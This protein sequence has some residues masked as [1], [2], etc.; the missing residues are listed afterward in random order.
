MAKVLEKWAK[1][2]QKR[3]HVNNQ[4]VTCGSVP[5]ADL[6]G[7]VVWLPEAG[8]CHTLPSEAD[9][10]TPNSAPDAIKFQVIQAS[11]PEI[12]PVAH[13]QSSNLCSFFK[14]ILLS[15]EGSSV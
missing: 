1:L 11:R 5:G 12:C 3:G 10:L 6:I 14:G 15:K 7:H 2:G 13:A 4:F 8:S 9:G